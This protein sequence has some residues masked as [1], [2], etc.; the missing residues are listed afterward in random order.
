MPYKDPIK[1]KEYLANR[2]KDLNQHSVDSITSGNI[3]DRYKWDMWCKQI[4]NGTKKNNRPYSDDFT[5]DIIFE[6]LIKGCFY[7]GE[8]ATTIDRIDSNLDHTPGNCVGCCFGC[9]ISKGAADPSTFIRKAYYRVREKYMD[10]ITNIWFINKQKPSMWHY[11]SR[12]E[13][14]G[15]M[16]GLNKEYW[17]T[18]IKGNCA[19]CKRS[20]DTWFGIDRIIPSEGYVV[21][22]VVSCCFDCNV[23]KW[24]DDVKTMV[25]RNERIAN[26]MDAGKLNIEDCIQVILHKGA[27]KTSIK[28]YAYGKIYASK[29]E[30]SRALGKGD[31]YVKNCIFL[32]IHSNDIFEINVNS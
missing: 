27:Q 8:L 20:P 9:N 30:A 1:N 24:E 6:M 15:F 22:N 26:R 21:G 17:S 4:K 14:K 25:E 13:K 28:V 18:L 32:G 31:S 3:I 7:C 23:D 5:N 2:I 29:R 12:A 16:F 11:K 19:Y 10:D